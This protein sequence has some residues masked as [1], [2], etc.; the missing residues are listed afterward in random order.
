MVAAASRRRSPCPVCT[1]R[2]ASGVVGWIAQGLGDL[3]DLSADQATRLEQV[4]HALVDAAIVLQDI[5][6]EERSS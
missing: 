6:G 1:L 4:R 5:G 2:T 3:T